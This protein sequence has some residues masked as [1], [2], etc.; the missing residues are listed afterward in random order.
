MPTNNE[1]KRAKTRALAALAR[2]GDAEE[3]AIDAGIARDPDNPVWTAADFKRARP[4]AEVFPRI[5]EAYRRRRGRGPQKAPTKKLVSLR[6]DRDV[7]QRFRATGKGWQ[8][9][10]NP[11]LREA[12]GLGP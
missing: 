7:L 4:A 10:I 1:R 3:A 6:L 12:V 5:V 9:R 8:A 2:V 11:A